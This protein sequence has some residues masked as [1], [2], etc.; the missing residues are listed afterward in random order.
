MHLRVRVRA[1]T[2]PPPPVPSESPLCALT[3]QDN[4]V[5]GWV[6]VMERFDKEDFLTD[7]ED[8]DDIELH[9]HGGRAMNIGFDLIVSIHLNFC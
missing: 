5:S 2:P 1:A 7:T 3:S 9:Q 4:A 6:L 8:D